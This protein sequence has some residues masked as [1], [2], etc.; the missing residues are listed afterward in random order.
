MIPE[1]IS[2]ICVEEGGEKKK[3]GKK[4]RGKN[5][6]HILQFMEL[7]EDINK[8]LKKFDSVAE[9]KGGGRERKE[10]KGEGE[11]RTSLAAELLEQL[12]PRQTKI[13]G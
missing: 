6:I 7:A 5:P 8:F 9:V 3:R 10:R 11:E 2:M 13:F 4:G 1:R 12:L